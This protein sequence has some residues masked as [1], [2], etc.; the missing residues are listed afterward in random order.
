VHL[1]IDS[2][3]RILKKWKLGEIIRE[4][5]IAGGD[6]PSGF[7]RGDWAHD[8][9]V[10]YRKSDDSIIISSRENFVIGI[11]YDTSAIKWI[12]GDTTKAWYQYPSL[13]K[14]AL[15]LAPGGIAPAGQHSVSITKD[16]HLLLFDNGRQSDHHSPAGVNRSYS[17]ARKYKLDLQARIATEVWNY[18]NNESVYSPYRSSVYEDAAE[19]YLVDY[20]VAKN[21]DGT[22]RGEILGLTPSGEKVFD[23]SYPTIAGF[24]AYRSLPIHWENLQFPPAAEARLGN[25]SARAQ[26]KTGDEVAI[27][28]FIV[29]GPVT[30]K[31]VVRGRGPSLEVNGQPLGGRLMNPVLELH[32]SS[33]QML[34]RNDDYQNDPN[35]G[36]IAQL[37]LAP[38]EEKEAALLAE[39][40]PGSYTA[41]L[42]GADNTTGIGL[43]EVFD[44]EPAASV[45]E[46]GNLSA[47]AFTSTGDN[48]LIGGLIIQG[49]IAKRVLF[50]ALG[51]ELTG[52]GVDNALQ[53]PTLELYGSN[54]MKIRSNDDWQQ[55][56]NAGEIAATTMAPTDP[57]E[58]AI[59]LPVG[60]GNYTFIV[61]G[62]NNTEGVALV[63]AF[64]LD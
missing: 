30:K 44:V 35:A 54:G 56:P 41:V 8:N 42:R 39:L 19:N 13:K 53:D 10:A 57:R 43:A 40:A 32:N 9:A 31:V 36:A 63:E 15:A 55:A 49:S 61:R 16:D 46:L 38:S 64:Q 33:N 6:D 24:V 22:R 59:L 12:L 11:D 20:A 25:L 34:Q 58:S 27:A 62:K 17:A 4:A 14:F 2:A 60:A 37:G 48:V 26:V 29:S 5:M 1:E 47:R 18:T 50:R 52:R 3:G 7:I 23:Y 51:P 21:P 28:G 45:A